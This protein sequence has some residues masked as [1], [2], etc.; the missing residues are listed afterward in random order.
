MFHFI[1]ERQC[2][3]KFVFLFNFSNIEPIV[4][5]QKIDKR[6]IKFNTKD[7][8]EKNS[9]IVCEKGLT[10]IVGKTNKFT[11]LHEKNIWIDSVFKCAVTNNQDCS[12]NNEKVTITS[13]P[14]RRNNTT[15]NKRRSSES[16]RTPLTTKNVRKES[17]NVFD[18][19]QTANCIKLNNTG[20][21]YPVYCEPYDQLCCKLSEYKKTQFGTIAN[22]TKKCYHYDAD[23]KEYTTKSNKYFCDCHLRTKILN[24]KNVEIA[25]CS[26]Y[27]DI[28]QN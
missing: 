16:T 28:D 10:A 3:Q 21:Y 11:Q 8:L 7:P 2:E 19:D 13:P 4:R 9:L 22:R 20:K 27:C 25:Y 17:K 24:E 5:Q 12:Q 1:V 6:N 14:R 26:R 18:C 23:S 15:T